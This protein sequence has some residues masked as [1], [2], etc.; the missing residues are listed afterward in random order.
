MMETEQQSV[1]RM[2]NDLQTILSCAAEHCGTNYTSS[3]RFRVSV[4][5][6]INQRR[7]WHDGAN[8]DNAF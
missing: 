7:L 4:S 2:T 6:V 1:T 5:V 8:V 3:A